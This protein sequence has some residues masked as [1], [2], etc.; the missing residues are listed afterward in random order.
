MVISS[1]LWEEM[2][3]CW[4]RRTNGDSAFLLVVLIFSIYAV[5]TTKTPFLTAYKPI[6][7]V[8]H[9]FPLPGNPRMPTHFS[10]YLVP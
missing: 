8:A 7:K 6:Y 1:V 5:I 10:K 4:Y 2:F 3:F 9:V